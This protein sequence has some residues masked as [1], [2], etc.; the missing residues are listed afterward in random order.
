M[1]LSTWGPSEPGCHYDTTHHH[2]D[3]YY[4]LEEWI[5]AQGA[6]HLIGLVDEVG[7]KSKP[8]R[9]GH[10]GEGGNHPTLPAHVR[11][12]PFVFYGAPLPAL[13]GQKDDTTY[14]NIH[15]HEP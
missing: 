8:G 9:T 2:K 7:G 13:S 12:G 14:L 15:I 11:C 6:P 5:L 3:G 4:H 1:G 10:V